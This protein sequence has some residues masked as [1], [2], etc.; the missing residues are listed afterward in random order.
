M[1][2]EFVIDCASN[3]I[4]ETWTERVDFAQLKESSRQ[5]W[6]H[7]DYRTGMH[8]IC[9][10]RLA[11]MDLTADEVWE[12]ASWFGERESVTKHAIVVSRE[13][14]FGMSRM[15]ASISATPAA[16][17]EHGDHVRVFYSLEAAEA[18]ISG[19]ESKP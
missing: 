17:Q 10:F 12:F 19:V 15:F 18:W 4:R 16:G 14:G 2:F 5:E 8:M 6:A 11:K 7:P 1:A 13:A 9:D 3:T